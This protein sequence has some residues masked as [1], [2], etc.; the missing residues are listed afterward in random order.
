[1]KAKVQQIAKQIILSNGVIK[2]KK[3]KLDILF[4]TCPFF[5]ASN[6]S[7]GIAYICEY[8]KKGGFKVEVYDLSIKIFN[9]SSDEFKKKWINMDIDYSNKKEIFKLISFS[10][11]II[12]EFLVYL[13][14]KNVRIIAFSILR[15]N[16]IFSYYV[17]S[18]IKKRFKD[19]IIIFGGQDLFLPQEG[20]DFF[21][22]CPNIKEVVDII[23]KG[24]GE[25]VTKEIIEN[26]KNK[27][28]VWRSLRKIKGMIYV[29]NKNMI[30]ISSKKNNNYIDTGKPEKILD[31]DNLPYPRYKEFNL[32]E[33]VQKVIPIIFGRG[34]INRCSFCVDWIYWN[35]YA[36]R[37]AHKVFEEI[38]YHIKENKIN[39][40]EFNDL[41][42]N[43]NLEKIRKFCDLVIK[44]RIKILWNCNCFVREDM[45]FELFK[46]MKEAGCKIIRIGIES[47]SDRILKLMNKNYKSKQASEMLK[48][49]HNGGLETHINIIVGFPGEVEKDLKKTL[50]FIKNNKNYIDKVL[51]VTCCAI[52]PN[53]DLEKN[54][55]KYGIIT[56]SKGLIMPEGKHACLWKDKFGNNRKE[57]E[58]RLLIVKDLLNS[59]KIP[60]LFLNK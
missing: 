14:K 59:L 28:L 43:I 45:S 33:Y 8:L 51:N 20:R 30:K 24:E 47:G 9:S 41:S 26:L 35:G 16:R 29:N 7:V 50:Y 2:M 5:G 18:E 4:V 60:V 23:V 15:S 3:N 22:E 44:Y 13:S 37:S 12:S 53:S 54:P 56:N 27:K 34:C 49:A 10:R 25:I 17:A 40:F 38:L 55:H 46:K 19:K 6:P 58:R 39:V 52:T 48:K 32:D 11:E 57:R 36:E 21:K 42:F 31:L 1:M